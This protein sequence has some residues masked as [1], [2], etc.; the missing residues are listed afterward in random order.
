METHATKPPKCAKSDR[1]AIPDLP[2]GRGRLARSQLYAVSQPVE[3][4]EISPKID[5]QNS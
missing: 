5:T 2:S 1:G 4:K 3:S